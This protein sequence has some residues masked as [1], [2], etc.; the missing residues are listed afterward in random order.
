MGQY[1]S[2]S[3]RSNCRWEKE[4]R[5]FLRRSGLFLG[6]ATMA[7]KM[8]IDL[9]QNGSTRQALQQVKVQGNHWHLPISLIIPPFVALRAQTRRKATGRPYH[10]RGPDTFLGGFIAVTR[11]WR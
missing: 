10:K 6:K 11:L 3:G 5:L 8:P 4:R 7:V 1:D 2:G 9:A